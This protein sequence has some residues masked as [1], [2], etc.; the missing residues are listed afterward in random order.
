MRC[1]IQHLQHLSHCTLRNT[2]HLHAESFWKNLL[3]FAFQQAQSVTLLP[4]KI[5][6]VRRI[7]VYNYFGT[8]IS[9]IRNTF[10]AVCLSHQL[11]THAFAK[12]YH[13]LFISALTGEGKMPHKPFLQLISGRLTP[14]LCF[15]CDM[16]NYKAHFRAEVFHGVKTNLGNVAEYV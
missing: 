14:S 4:Q 8:L 3:M 9:K 5:L 2:T 13:R 11:H 7:C 12:H 10:L 6:N 15:F 16:W 1:G